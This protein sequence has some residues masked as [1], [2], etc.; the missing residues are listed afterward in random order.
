[1]HQANV[2]QEPSVFN[3]EGP[4]PHLT[5]Q[6]IAAWVE[7]TTPCDGA[8]GRSRKALDPVPRTSFCQG[9]QKR[10]PIA[11]LFISCWATWM[12]VWHGWHG[13]QLALG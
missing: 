3:R 11:T 12:R 7:D 5:C 2:P 4:G 9:E 1:M 10:L 13:E 6:Q 8:G